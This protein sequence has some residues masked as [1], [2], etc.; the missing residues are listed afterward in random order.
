LITWLLKEIEKNPTS[1][2]RKSILLNKSE[3]Q[4]EKLKQKSFLEYSQ[5]SQ[6]HETYPCERS[7]SNTCP[8]DVVEMNGNHFAICSEN[9]EI[10]PVSLS[11]DDISKYSFSLDVLI[12]AVRKAN[13]LTGSSYP[14]T[15]RLYFVG[16]RVVNGTNT[17]FVM[18]FFT[19]AQSAEPQIL[20]LMARVPANYGQTIVITPSLCLTQESIYSK[21]KASSIF[22]VTLSSTFGQ[23]DF[24]INYLAAL[25]KR[26]PAD[27]VSQPTSLTNEQLANCE[28]HSYLCRADQ[29]YI[30]GTVPQKR[31]NEIFLNG[32][33]LS[34]GDSLFALLMRF[35]V[36]LKK[37]DGG[38][39]SSEDLYA[40]GFINN[41]DT[42]QH[43]S[44]LR[45]A[46][47]GG[48]KDKDGSKFIEASKSKKY[49]ISAHPDFIT[50]D[51]EKLFKHP[52]SDI[53]ALAKK[54][55]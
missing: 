24:K 43:Y 47:K 36:E 44:N 6:N 45:T 41:P 9:S 39:V 34:L 25:R 15:T 40:E 30:P 21:L 29:L 7:C 13:G 53:K 28:K 1:L 3:E 54:L 26:H 4:F 17:A 32:N 48:L 16:E 14:L 20:S 35:V 2:F 33:K 50:Y 12:E 11:K 46:L 52:D 10:D 31:S 51:K 42:Y 27:I 37:G 22:P 49:R 38:W 5:L 55:P 23:D 19:S 8:M 18:A